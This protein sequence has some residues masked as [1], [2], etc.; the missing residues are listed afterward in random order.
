MCAWKQELFW[1]VNVHLSLSLSS[2]QA[3]SRW[4]VKASTAS[5]PHWGCQSS[6][7]VSCRQSGTRQTPKRRDRGRH[8][9]YNNNSGNKFE[10]WRTRWPIGIT[11]SLTLTMLRGGGCVFLPAWERK[12]ETDK[13]HLRQRGQMAGEF[14]VGASTHRGKRIPLFLPSF[15]SYYFSRRELQW[16]IELGM[17]LRLIYLVWWTRKENHSCSMHFDREPKR[18]NEVTKITPLHVGYLACARG[19]AGSNA[20]VWHTV[21][22]CII[23]FLWSCNS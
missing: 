15:L 7:L 6:P 16:L 21:K 18:N 4:S 13:I 5:P 9:T 1:P 23:S 11:P 19:R 10:K 12:I 3:G 2:L 17:N 20:S 8:R 14:R 22:T